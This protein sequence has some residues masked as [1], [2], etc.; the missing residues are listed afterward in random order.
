MMYKEKSSAARRLSA[1]LLAPALA[2]G[3]FATAIPAVA[4]V[5]DSFAEVSFASDSEGKVTKNSEIEKIADSQMSVAQ[6]QEDVAE[7]SV[8]ALEGDGRGV[9]LIEDYQID[10]RDGDSSKLANDSSGEGDTS[11][12]AE[13]A[14]Q[15]RKVYTSV[16][17]IAEFPGGMPALLQYLSGHITYPEEAIKNNEQGL[18]V[19]KFVIE[20]D[21]SVSEPEVVKSVSSSLD[22]EATRVVKELPRWTPGT[23]DG[24]PV[25]VWFTLPVS[26]QLPEETSEKR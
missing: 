21:G 17:K 4:R 24:S 20:A 16:E 9:N 1:L 11:L 12:P 7:P 3:C 13:E 26:F 14:T 25:P 10:Q 22:A 15:D 18:V 8:S 5:L 6:F 19:V 23:I 2:A